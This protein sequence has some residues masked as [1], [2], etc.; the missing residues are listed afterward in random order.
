MH[1][2]RI[3]VVQILVWVALVL[4]RA[5]Q[6]LGVWAAPDAVRA[7]GVLT[8]VAGLALIIIAQVQMG[9]SWRIGIDP[10]VPTAL[11]TGGLFRHVRN[12]IFTGL[13]LW[14]GALVLLTPSAWTLMG[15]G[16]LAFNLAIQVRLEEAHLQ[17]VHGDTYRHYAATAGRFVPGLGRLTAS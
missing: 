3:S 16:F 2:F 8:G 4:T 14:T 17:R 13:L 9:A 11:V 1:G 15:W 5:P 10:D 12:P 7:A 6:T